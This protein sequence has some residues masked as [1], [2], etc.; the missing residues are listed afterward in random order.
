MPMSNRSSFVVFA[1]GRFS[2]GRPSSFIS[3]AGMGGVISQQYRGTGQ[4]FSSRIMLIRHLHA[5]MTAAAGACSPCF[6]SLN[7]FRPIDGLVDL[8]LFRECVRRWMALAFVLINRLGTGT[9][10]TNDPP[11]LARILFSQGRFR[12]GYSTPR[13]QKTCRSLPYQLSSSPLPW[14]FLRRR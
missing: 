2:F 8:P 1:D 11:S 3:C 4:V 12:I 5:P 14:G 9:T 10:L 7:F 6:A 13:G